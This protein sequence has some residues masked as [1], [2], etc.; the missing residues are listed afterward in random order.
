MISK[1]D[2]TQDVTLLEAIYTLLN[3]TSQKDPFLVSEEQQ[4][5]IYRAQKDIDLG[6]Y[7]LNEDLNE[8]VTKWLNK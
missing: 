6:N 4:D 5:S 2:D 1:I 8:E 7:I 3:S